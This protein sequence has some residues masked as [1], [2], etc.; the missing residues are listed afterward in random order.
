MGAVWDTFYLMLG[1]IFQPNLRRYAATPLLKTN[2]AWNA[3]Y[4]L[5]IRFLA[6]VSGLC[7]CV[8]YCHRK[9]TY[10]CITQFSFNKI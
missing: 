9:E 7:I 8:I 5:F 2:G 1:F 6:V 4:L 10:P 3:L